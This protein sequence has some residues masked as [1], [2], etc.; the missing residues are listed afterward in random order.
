[1]LG[2]L[3]IFFLFSVRGIFA[4]SITP[5]VTIAPTATPSATTT[6]S[7]STNIVLSEFMANASPEWV[8]IRNNSSSPK[9]ISGWKLRDSTENSRNIPSTTIPAYGFYV[10]ETNTF[11]NNDSVDQ[12][13]IFDESNTL[14]DSTSYASAD[15]VY[16]WTKNPNWCLAVQSKGSSNNSCLASTPTPSPTITSTPSPTP[17]PTGTPGPTSPPSATPTPYPTSTPIPSLA[18]IPTDLPEPTA[19]VE[20]TPNL[21]PSILGDTIVDQSGIEDLIFPTPTPKL[22]NVTKTFSSPTLLAIIFISLGGFLLLIPV[23]M[24]KLRQ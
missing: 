3:I 15:N 2:F 11:L 18:P 9:S 20:P 24:I 4:Q 16:S 8:E 10:F 6:P 23:V 22:N 7:A 13:R 1:M 21:T 5:S 12:V 19:V 17:L 14:V